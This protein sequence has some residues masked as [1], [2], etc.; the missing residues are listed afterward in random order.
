VSGNDPG[1]VLAASEALRS[2]DTE[3]S[4]IPASAWPGQL[5][6]LDHPGLYAWWVDAKGAEALSAGLG[7]TVVADRI[8]VGQAGAASSVAHHPS[9]STLRSRIGR[10]HLA[11]KVRSSTLRRTLASVLLAPLALDLLGPRLL[12][13][14]SEAQLTEWMREHLSL[15]VHG[16]DSGEHLAELEKRVVDAL[17]PP[18]NVEHMPACPLR[19]RLRQL[20]AVV[21]RGIDDLWIPPD[22]ALVDWRS[23]LGEYGQAFD[24]YRYASLV[25]RRECSEVL[26]EVLRLLKSEGEIAP[27]FGD[28]R[29]A[30]Y[31]LQRCVH[32]AE[33]SPGWEPDGELEAEVH[34]LYAAIQLAWQTTWSVAV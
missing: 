6:G 33:Q 31:W 24:G 23:I 3:P 15:A 27:T 17:Q 10:N 20:R 34:R 18:L 8:Y 29:C 26:D 28:L 5:A 14:P 1:P 22:P 9:A 16:V 13:A 19:E 4:R 30:L 2:L 12:S 25:R 7:M 21:L 11:G 32:S